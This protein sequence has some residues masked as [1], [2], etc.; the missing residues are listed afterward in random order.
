MLLVHNASSFCDILTKAVGDW[1]TGPK[2][3]ALR[4]AL[5][6]ARKAGSKT[7]VHAHHIVPQTVSKYYPNVAKWVERR[8]GPQGRQDP[9]GRLNES[10]L[11]L[12]VGPFRRI[13]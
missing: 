11:G 4:K 7:G 8:K 5:E 9:R 10:H 12:E 2:F 3:Q 6:A 13:R 1:R